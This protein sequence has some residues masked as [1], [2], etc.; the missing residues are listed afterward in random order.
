MPYS[1]TEEFLLGVWVT[2]VG[3]GKGS[4]APENGVCP[5][6]EGDLV[7][8]W[9]GGGRVSPDSCTLCGDDF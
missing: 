8:H 5:S 2:L 1:M 9:W 3:A 4:S 7:S 6:C